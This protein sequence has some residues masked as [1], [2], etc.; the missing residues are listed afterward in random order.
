M[1]TGMYSSGSECIGRIAVLHKG[2]RRG[3]SGRT[4]NSDLVHG[5][6]EFEAVVGRVA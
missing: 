4:Y 3:I 2:R 1:G 6:G 5:C